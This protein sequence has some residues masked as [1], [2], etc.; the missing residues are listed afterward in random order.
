MGLKR[1]AVA[2]VRELR[3]FV[4]ELSSLDRVWPIL[5][6]D[7]AGKWHNLHLTQYQATFFVADM[8]NDDTGLE[9]DLGIFPANRRSSM[10]CI[11]PIW[12]ATGST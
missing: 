10:S 9:I 5:F 1:E 3:G 7:R 2:F 12:D 8:D 4:P 6:P 11:T